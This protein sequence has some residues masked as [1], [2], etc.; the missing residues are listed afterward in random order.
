MRAL[1]GGMNKMV[2][3]AE[4]NKI[5]KVNYW[6]IF[7]IAK[8]ILTVIPAQAA[9]PLIDRLAATADALLHDHLMRSHDLT[10]EVFQSLIA[11][12]KFLAAFYTTPPAAAL[13]A[14]LAISPD[15]TPAKGVWADP[16]DVAALRIADLACGTGTLLSTAYRRV[17]QL[18]E[19]R[20]GDAEA[21]HPRMM[22]ASLIGC[23]VLPAAAHLTAS[24][25]AGAHPTVT[26]DHSSII[27]VEYGPQ[28]GGRV[29]LGSLDLASTQQAFDA[30]DITGGFAPVTGGQA[31]G[32]TGQQER[33]L[34][35]TLPHASFDL[36][37][38]NPPFTRDTGQEGK[39]VGVSNPMFAAFK[40]SAA[41]QKRMAEAREK[42][43]HGTSA[44][45][46]AGEASDFLVLADRKLKP[47]GTLGL[48]MPLS[49]M[50]G[51]AWEASRQMLRKNYENLVLVTISGALDNELSFS[52]DTGMGECLVVGRR[53]LQESKRATF[54]VLN[55]RPDSYL[56]GSTAASEIALGIKG[57][58]RRLEDGPVGGTP[59]RLGADIVGYALD[60][61]LPETGGW[62]V[63]R[64]ADVSL[65]QAAYQLADCG[66]A[67]LPG[68]AE[69]SAVAVPVT[70]VVKIA[71]I[72]P[73]HMDVAGDTQTG[74]VRGPFFRQPIAPNAAPTYPILW[75]H[76]APRERTMEFPAD[77]EGLVRQGA[78][79]AEEFS[80]RSR[81]EKVWATATHC[82][83]NR[84]F[85]FNSQS[86]AMQFTPVRTIGGHAWP[87]VRLKSEEQEKALVL[88]GNSTLG[89]LLHWWH[90]NKQQAGRGRSGISLLETLPV[91][92]VA[93][94]SAEALRK[95]AAIFDDL[96]GQPMLTVNEIDR[97]DVRAHL[98]ERFYREVLGFPESLLASG[99]PLTLLRQKLAIEPSIA[100]SKL[101]A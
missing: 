85:R 60:A 62:K 34:W 90:A 93:A 99:G 92:D 8:R 29:A 20:G 71:S 16:E 39:K 75:T 64:M 46:N 100:G 4:W 95:A 18:H 19:A 89:L 52:A 38:M 33:D 54:V 73:Y 66:R 59:I 43:F 37:L 98:D 67:W 72:G 91:L 17:S 15:R 82:H 48:V 12:R 11:D 31:I 14:G 53:T 26:F 58:L 21:L 13:L 10:G 78:D 69:S 57:Q 28:K 70:T 25:L 88:R 50:M 6:A 76:S 55:R 80:I 27:T 61:P 97:D 81:A 94:L 35:L 9:Q 74:G 87:S 24:M 36:I 22:A 68:A 47:G 2:V 49:L 83:F 79:A 40:T 30:L 44:H 96:K 42:L 77:C 63:V 65:A 7:D 32:G 41:V 51:D 86:T 84:D 5:L 3:L 23:D 101:K 45:G 1:P 56:E